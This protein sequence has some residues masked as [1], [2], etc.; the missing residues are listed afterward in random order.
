MA[1]SRTL[2]TWLPLFACI[3]AACSSPESQAGPDFGKAAAG[4]TVAAAAPASAPQ[5]TTLDV[6]ISGS[7]FDNR[8]TAQL[9]RSGVADSRVRTNS[10]RYL[11]TTALVANVT[12]AIDAVVSSYDVAVTTG[13]GKKGIGSDLFIVKTKAPTPPAD[14]AITF[15][16][17]GNPDG[18]V[19]MNADGTNQASVYHSV[20]VNHPSWS[21]SGTQIAFDG[22]DGTVTLPYGVYVADIGVVAGVPHASNVHLVLQRFQ[23][24]QPDWSPDGSQLAVTGVGGTNLDSSVV[25]TLPA[26]GGPIQV[27]ATW[28]ASSPRHPTV[29]H[30]TWSPDGTRIAFI[31]SDYLSASD[32]V[33]AL[34]LLNA[35]DN[36]LTIVYT[37]SPSASLQVIGRPDWSPDGSALLVDGYASADPVRRLYRIAP[38][39]GALPTVL[40]GTEKA[41]GAR[42]SPAGT[43]LTWG[44]SSGG[45]IYRYSFSSAVSSLLSRVGEFPDWRR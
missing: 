24:G 39:S 33:T 6:Q 37:A 10:T 35:A 34:M 18:L 29:S 42:W 20:Y 38:A 23:S 32:N 7:G 4:P 1:V 5:D 12:I 19:V 25:A 8:S 2:S 3:A 11:S 13:A 36:Q 15:R 26:S 16:V 17:P 30:A 22:G 41:Y 28:W 14:P 27:R 44:R 43:E 31:Y 45:G 9:L 40:P 21:P